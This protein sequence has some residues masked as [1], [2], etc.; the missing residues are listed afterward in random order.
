AL[1]SDAG[2]AAVREG[3]DALAMMLSIFA[4]FTAE[5]AWSLL[6][7]EPSVVFAGWPAYDA[8]LL[9]ESV[10]TCVVQVQGKVRDRLEVAADIGEDELRELALAAPGVVRALDGR[11]VRTVIVRAPKLVNV[12]PT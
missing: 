8:A 10:V 6:G 2:A 3:A 9:V 12:V 4:P 5:E 7:H 11:E 1:N